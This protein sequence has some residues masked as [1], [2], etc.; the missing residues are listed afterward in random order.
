MDADCA[1]ILQFCTATES[2]DWLQSISTNINDLTLENIKKA[3][4]YSSP[5]E[6]MVHMGWVCEN[7]LAKDSSHLHSSKFLVLKGSSL[8]V[9]SRPPVTTSDWGQVESVHNLC[10]VLFKANKKLWVAEDCWMQAKMFRG[11]HQEADHRDERALCFSVLL[12][13]GHMHNYSVELGSDLALWEKSFQTAICTEVQKVGSK[14]Y[15]CS[16]QGKVLCF[17]IDFES[18]FACTECT[19][20]V[21]VWRYRFSQLRGSSDDGKTRV[22][23]LF[24]NPESK[25]IE[26]KELEFANLT[27]VLHCIH[28]FMAA[29]VASVDPAFAARKH[30]HSS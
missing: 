9:F 29:K 20:K 6:Q 18:G 26:M 27:A 21:V 13:H 3:N 15:M 14:T 28:S 24:Q 2:T 12:G 25:Q 10:E 17:T 8:Y 1:A 16:S 5:E 11:Q 23:L 22:K 30:P 19:S 7:L 4:K